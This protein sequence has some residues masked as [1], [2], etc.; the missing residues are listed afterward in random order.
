MRQ[1]KLFGKTLKEPPSGEVAK[2]AILLERGGFIEKTMSGVYTFLPLGW[3]V[4][5]K[6]ENIVR[7]EMNRAGAEELFMPALHPKE[8]WEKTGRW[9]SFDSLF[10][11]KSAYKTEYALGPTHEEIIY[12]LAT[13][14]IDSYKD[15][16]V[17][18]YQIQ[19]KFRDEPRAKSGLLRGREF[20]MK[21][22]YSFHV[23]NEDRDHYYEVMRKAYHKVFNRTG[24]TAIDVEASGGTFSELSQE[25]QVA[26]D[27]GEDEIYV[28][29]KCNFGTNKELAENAKD[30][31][32]VKC[33][34]CGDKTVKQKT[35][36]VGNIF[37]LKEKFAKDFGLIFKDQKGGSKFVAAGCYGLGTTRLMGT[38]AEVHGDKAGVIWPE[39]IAPFKAHLIRI[40]K[41]ESRIVDHADKLYKQLVDYGVKV[42]YDDRDDKSAGEKFAD[43]DL[44][45]IPYRL[46]VS[47]KTIKQNAVEIKRRNEDKTELV[48][49]KELIAK[50]T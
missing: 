2:N 26:C 50:L 32:R 1:S 39:E 46:V 21:D 23:S 15:L 31:L 49:L 43:A 28:C 24:L 16:P 47:G 17:Y 12:P 4:L 35:A 3:R 13:H 36:E 34:K 25:F 33:R 48:K 9:Q 45:G 8:N 29:K 40:M 6:I 41:H 10:K 7:E 14:F 18:L 22:L 44:I 27:A 30:D 38:V 5:S 20:R 11:I 37:P 19:T 42:L